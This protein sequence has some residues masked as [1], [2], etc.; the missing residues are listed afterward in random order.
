MKYHFTGIPNIKREIGR[1]I[2]GQ[3]CDVLTIAS[4]GYPEFVQGL[5]N[6]LFFVVPITRF[7][8]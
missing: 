7:Y 1:I 8:V 5:K 3:A 2:V 6:F 4:S